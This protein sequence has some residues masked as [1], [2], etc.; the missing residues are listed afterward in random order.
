MT[1]DS[2]I[3]L[4]LDT[5]GCNDYYPSCADPYKPWSGIFFDDISVSAKR[6]G[7]KVWEDVVIIPGPCDPSETCSD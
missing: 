6:V 1:Y 3:G 7:D 2:G 5:R 4:W